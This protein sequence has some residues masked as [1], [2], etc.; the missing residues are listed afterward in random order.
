VGLADSPGC[1]VA[2]EVRHILLGCIAE[3]VVHHSHCSDELLACLE[4]VDLPAIMY[5]P[6][7]LRRRRSTI[8]SLIVLL[9]R[10][11]A[12]IATVMA[13]ALLSRIV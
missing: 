8:S 3:V 5:I 4:Q 12:W 11:T 7:L 13:A 1:I 2:A 6:I 9:R 10:W